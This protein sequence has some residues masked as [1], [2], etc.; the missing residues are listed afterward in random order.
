MSIFSWTK[1][2]RKDTGGHQKAAPPQ[3]DTAPPPVPNKNVSTPI[4]QDTPAAT[5]KTTV[6]AEEIRTR[7]AAARRMKSDTSLR[8]RQYTPQPC[9]GTRANKEVSTPRRSPQ[10]TQSSLSINEV[11]MEQPH[12]PNAPRSTPQVRGR[13]LKRPHEAYSTKTRGNHPASPDLYKLPIPQ[14]VRPMS[15]RPISRRT[16]LPRVKSPLSKVEEP[17]KLFS[18]SSQESGFSATSSQSTTTSGSSH[19]SGTT[20]TR[21]SMQVSKPPFPKST[22]K[23]KRTTEISL[24][25]SSHGDMGNAKKAKP[26]VPAWRYEDFVDIIETPPKPA[27]GQNVRISLSSVFRRRVSIAC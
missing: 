14:P 16:S 9:N 1:K 17:D 12:R 21:S 8:T 25:Y 3:T 23:L 2:V 20:S 5:P 13:Q 11:V 6:T 4:A 7:I 15:N 10:R 27:S 22:A 24:P 18:S 26:K 19:Y